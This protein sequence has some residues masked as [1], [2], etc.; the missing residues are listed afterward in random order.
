MKTCH[1]CGTEWTGFGQPGVKASCENCDYDLHACLNC[2][3]YDIHKPKE[4]MIDTDTVRDKE[5][6]NYCEEFQFLDRKQGVA[7]D[8][9]QKAKDAFNSLFRK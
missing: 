5:R 6:F 2:R 1:K 3:F 7:V 9:K 4:C 8:E